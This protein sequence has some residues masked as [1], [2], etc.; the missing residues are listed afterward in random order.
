MRA[1]IGGIF[2]AVLLG[3]A[4]ALN[5]LASSAATPHHTTHKSDK[6]TIVLVHG[7]WAD[8]SSWRS[9]TAK[10]Q[11]SGYTVDV[12]ANPLRGVKSD[13][14]YLKDRLSTIPGPIVLVAHSYGG[15]VITGAATGNSHV[16][17]LVYIDAYVPDT[18]D[19]VVALTGPNSSLDP[20]TTLDAVPLHDATGAV[21]DVDLYVKQAVFPAIFAGGV[22][23]S[24]AAVLA[25]G[26]RPLTLS[27]LSEKF[28]GAPAWETIPSWDLIGTADRV[29]P[30]AEQEKMAAR[31]GAQVVRVDAPHLSMVSDPGAV[32]SLIR[33]AAQHS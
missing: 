2:I 29:I 33:T 18:G 14:G 6:P 12:A 30:R 27:A 24:T 7:A 16:K 28:T 15:M 32:A 4:L 31:A 10:L 21:Y 11:K 20:A 8:G 25:A 1:A 19:N 22:R 3:L 26:Q 9:V 13:T 5:P 17:A 23:S